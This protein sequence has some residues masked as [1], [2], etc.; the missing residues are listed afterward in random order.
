MASWLQKEELGPHVMHSQS[1]NFTTNIFSILIKVHEKSQH[2][3]AVLQNQQ[4]S[5]LIM[6]TKWFH[7]TMYAVEW[8][9]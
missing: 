1:F 3:V 6:K 9:K 5:G 8:K 7:W 4:C 2:L